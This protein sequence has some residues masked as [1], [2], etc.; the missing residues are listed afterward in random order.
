MQMR[1]VRSLEQL[2]EPF[3][4]E[5]NAMEMRV[6]Q[7]ELELTQVTNELQSTKARF[8]EAESGS[9]SCESIGATL[10]RKRVGRLSLKR[11]YLSLQTQSQRCSF[12]WNSRP[13]CK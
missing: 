5:K 9:R 10:G 12:S 11:R 2:V 13:V 1:K 6:K 8:L 7:I 3:Q 4:R